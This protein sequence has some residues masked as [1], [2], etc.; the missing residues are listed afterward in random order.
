MVGQ[1]TLNLL[2]L[3]RIQASERSEEDWMRSLCPRAKRRG[4]SK[5]R[6]ILNLINN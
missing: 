5:P 4:K 2:I 1:Q 3:V 6:N